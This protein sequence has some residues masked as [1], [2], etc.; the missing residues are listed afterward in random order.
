[1]PVRRKSDQPTSAEIQ[2]SG[3]LCGIPPEGKTISGIKAERRRRGASIRERFSHWESKRQGGRPL[4]E[5]AACHYEIRS[6]PMPPRKAVNAWRLV[7]KRKL[8]SLANPLF[9][10]G[11]PGIGNVGKVAIDFAIDELKAEKIYEITSST[12][13]H[14]VFVTDG[15]LV[16]LP[17]IEIFHKRVQGRDLLLMGGDVQPIDEAGCYDFTYHLLDLLQ[18]HRVR[19]IITLGG[20]GLADI[21]KKPKVY[22]T[23]NSKPI[24]DAYHKELGDA[25]ERSLYGVVGPIIGVSGLLVGLAAQR[26]IRAV[27]LLAETYGHPMYLGIAGAKEMLKALDRKLALR[28]NLKKLEKEIKSIEAEMLKRVEQMGESAAAGMFIKGKGQEVNYIG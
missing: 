10:E 2:P 11:L 28:L 8:A 25:V 3:Y 7:R 4:R 24:V 26:N 17:T 27:C 16:E 9:I 19:E 18:K 20:I 22:V 15:N 6:E 13:P 5:V 1:M 14:S 12:F 23:G 21:P